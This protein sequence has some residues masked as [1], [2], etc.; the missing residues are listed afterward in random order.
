MQIPVSYFLLLSA[1]L[2]S[3]GIAIVIVKR[4]TIMILM[5]I[6]LMLNAVN[7]NLVAFSRNDPSL[8]G[9]SMTLFVLVV[10][11]AEA[12]VVLAIVLLA[13]KQFKT[14]NMDDFAEME[15]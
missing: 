9:Q 2:F 12:V 6:E 3:I 7:I 15:G 4:H 8:Q 11:A 13:Y 5:G 1:M 14:V 10:A